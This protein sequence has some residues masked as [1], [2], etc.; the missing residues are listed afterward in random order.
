M[1]YLTEGLVAGGLVAGVVWYATR[2][3]IGR[4]HV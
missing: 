3:Q 4:A 2:D 1:R